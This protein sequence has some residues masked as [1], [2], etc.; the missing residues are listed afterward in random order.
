MKRTW[1]AVGIVCLAALGLAA[2]QLA[3]QERGDTTAVGV[4]PLVHTGDELRNVVLN[5][6]GRPSSLTRAEGRAFESP[7]PRSKN[8]TGLDVKALQLGERGG[9]LQGIGVGALQ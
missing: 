3:A 9:Q 7:V 5:L 2:P 8:L 1:R 4:P 6:P